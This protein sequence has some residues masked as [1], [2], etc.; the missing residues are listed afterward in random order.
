M[1]DDEAIIRRTFSLYAKYG[2]KSISLD[3]IARDMGISKKTIYAHVKNRDQLIERV[4]EFSI[5][6]FVQG[7]RS[8]IKPSDDVFTQLGVF[9]AYH[10]QQLRSFNPSFL[11]DL[12]KV[13]CKLFNRIKHVRDHRIYGLAEEILQQGI[14]ESLFR[15]DLDVKYIYLSQMAKVSAL[16]GAPVFDE[17]GPDFELVLFKLILNEIRGMT[18]EKGFRKMDEKYDQLLQLIK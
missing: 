5:R 1:I 10:I 14:R 15:D 17:R 12:K 4:V 3:E 2:I 8:L 9:Y 6:Q 18:T 13:N 7:L 16:S 11:P